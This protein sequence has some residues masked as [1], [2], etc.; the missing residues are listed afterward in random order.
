MTTPGP[1][2]DDDSS[3]RWQ[4]DDTQQFDR[5]PAGNP[6]GQQR[7]DYAGPPSGGAYYVVEEPL[8][9]TEEEL[10]GLRGTGVPPPL[11]ST[12]RVLP[13]E[14]EASSVVQK[15]LFPTEKFRGEWRRHRAACRA[16]RRGSVTLSE[17]KGFPSGRDP[18]LR[19]G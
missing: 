19:S 17:A 12:Q 1:P 14:D 10:A 7:G 9:L 15:Y 6:A 3:R 5:P 13:L 4:D 8:P 2:S 18:S 11:L 16:R